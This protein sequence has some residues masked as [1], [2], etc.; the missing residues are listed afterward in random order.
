M[1]DRRRFLIA[2][3][4]TGAPAGI[5]VAQPIPISAAETQAVFAAATVRVLK[6]NIARRGKVHVEVPPLVE[7]GNAVPLTVRVD[8]PMTEAAHVR[9]IHVF[10]EKN[11]QPHVFSC[12]LGPRAGKAEVTTRARIADTQEVTAIAELSDGTFWIGSAPVRV[13]LSACLEDGLI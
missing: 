9:S 8:S 6:G 1:M 2:A 5:A 3:A 7:N 13:T 11:P 10:A 12:T 4:A